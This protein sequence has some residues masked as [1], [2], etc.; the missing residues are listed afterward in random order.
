MV[1]IEELKVYQKYADLYYYTYLITE[2][3]PKYEKN[4]IVSD[5]KNCTCNGLINIINAQKI[6]VSKVSFLFLL[7]MQGNIFII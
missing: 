1:S 5:I 4:G 3:F 7:Y 2:K 6:N